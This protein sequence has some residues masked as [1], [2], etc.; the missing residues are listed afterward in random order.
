MTDEDFSTLYELNYFMEILIRSR[1]SCA[2]LS[3]SN[4]IRAMGLASTF[5][6]RRLYTLLY[7][8]CASR[9]SVTEDL[10]DQFRQ[11]LSKMK[12][13]LADDILPPQ[14]AEA[15][16]DAVVVRQ[17][18]YRLSPAQVVQIM[19]KSNTSKLIALRCTLAH[20]KITP[21][22]I[23]QLASDISPH[24]VS[25]ML[26]LLFIVLRDRDFDKFEQLFS[27]YSRHLENSPTYW[28]VGTTAAYVRKNYSLCMERAEKCVRLS[29]LDQLACIYLGRSA[30]RR[31]RWWTSFITLRAVL[32]GQACVDRRSKNFS[33]FNW[34]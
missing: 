27:D 19:P 28:L 31:G 22:D 14:M 32:R 9:P 15:I 25:G 29:P 21:L 10:L 34:V 18:I 13:D 7:N 20:K 4:L 6:L 12:M 8:V 3:D 5:Q 16:Q 33:A 30:F 23:N 24:S 26:C 17:L 11:S 2:G 1:C